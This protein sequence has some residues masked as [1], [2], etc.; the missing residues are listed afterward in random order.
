[1]E[2]LVCPDPNCPIAQAK[3][4]SVT[5]PKTATEIYGCRPDLC[6]LLERNFGVL[7]LKNQIDHASVEPKVETATA[8]PG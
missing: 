7:K 8:T 1:M 4:T 2:R 6:A 3:G 5:D